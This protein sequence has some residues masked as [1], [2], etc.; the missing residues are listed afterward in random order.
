M[1]TYLTWDPDWREYKSNW[2]D[3]A[4]N[5][6]G[7]V[8]FGALLFVQIGKWVLGIGRTGFGLPASGF[9]TKDGLRDQK[10]EN[11]DRIRL[12]AIVFLTVL[13][14]FGVSM[15]IELL[16]AYLPSRDSSLRDL[17]ANTA[18]TLIGA[19]AAVWYSRKRIACSG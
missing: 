17:V 13:V 10:R 8:P 14:G 11:I 4:V 19:L 12:A 5:I 6:L 16:Q 18:G 9:G 3:L 1:R 15:A 7:F 2:L